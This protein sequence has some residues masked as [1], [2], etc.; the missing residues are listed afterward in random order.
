M[1]YLIIDRFEGNYAVCEQEDKSMINVPKYKLPLNC[2]EGDSLILDS[3]GMYQKDTQNSQ[4]RE[5]RISEKMNRL[6][7]R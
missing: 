6:F 5:K 7:D 1:K 2:N 4:N 3:D